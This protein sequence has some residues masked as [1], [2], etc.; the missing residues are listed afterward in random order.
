MYPPEQNSTIYMHDVTINMVLN[1]GKTHFG[2][3]ENKPK[4]SL[5]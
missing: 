3:N 5:Y 2:Q 4:L 1:G